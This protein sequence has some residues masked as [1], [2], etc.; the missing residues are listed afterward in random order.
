MTRCSFAAGT[1]R[2]LTLALVGA[3]LLELLPATLARKLASS[4]FAAGGAANA[5]LA[6]C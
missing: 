5:L 3:A 1:M 4:G 2:S 6:C